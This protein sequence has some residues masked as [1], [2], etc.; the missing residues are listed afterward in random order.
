LAGV[1]AGSGQDG[2]TAAATPALLRLDRIY[3]SYPPNVQ[4]LRGISLELRAGEVSALLGPN[5]AGKSTLVRIMTG[6]ERPTTGAMMLDGTA[7]AFAGP[8]AA[9]EKGVA[10]VYQ[11]LPLLPNLSAAENMSLGHTGQ[12]HL[13]IWRPGPSRA[14]Y[15]ELASEIPDA[16]SP[17]AIVGRLTVAQRQKVAFIRAL[18]MK[19]RLLIVDE[20]TSSLSMEERQEMQV[21]LRQLAHSRQI[22]VVTISHFI[23]D[24]LSGADRIVVLRDGLIALDKPVADTRHAEVLAVLSGGVAAAPSPRSQPAAPRRASQGSRL[25]VESLATSGVSPL[26]FTVDVGECVGLYG[27]PGCGATEIL[28]AIAGLDRHSGTLRWN[29]EILPRSM[30]KRVLR[31]VVYCDGDRG[32]NLILPW[33]VGR[34]IGLP[35][36]FRQ[37]ALSIPSRRVENQRARDVIARFA[38]KGTTDEAIRNLSGGNQQRVAVARTISLGVPLLLLGDDLTRGVDVVGRTH[39]HGLLRQAAEAGAAI[40]LYSSDPDEL[41]DLCDRVVVLRDGIIVREVEGKEITVP[42]LEGEAQKRRH[43]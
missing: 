11:E 18:S 1:E 32:K 10:A 23:E 40:L 26:S 33:T 15:V 38:I 3:K 31:K 39:I 17:D 41:V 8:A 14:T 9:A 36:L 20:G 5:G 13:A 16:P 24:A 25:E 37:P 7:I 34:N 35:Y 6:V 21:L 22:A 12:P 43:G 30:A 19:P 29:G 4:A 28:R 27:P 2:R 42:V